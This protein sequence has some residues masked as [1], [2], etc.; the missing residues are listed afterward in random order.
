MFG[1]L[2]PH[3]PLVGRAQCRLR[4]GQRILLWC[5]WGIPQKWSDWGGSPTGATA[6]SSTGGLLFGSTLGSTT[7]GSLHGPRRLA[8]PD[9]GDGCAGLGLLGARIERFG[10]TNSSSGGLFS[11][12]LFGSTSGGPA[13]GP[14]FGVNRYKYGHGWEIPTFSATKTIFTDWVRSFTFT[15]FNSAFPWLC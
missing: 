1:D 15:Y 6:G 11:G 13:S 7:S 14:L 9:W 5:C 4:V 3:R 12:G 8:D 10:S 2:G